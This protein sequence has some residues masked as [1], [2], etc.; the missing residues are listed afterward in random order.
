M[1]DTVVL[2]IHN[3]TKYDA[4]TKVLTNYSKDS[5]TKIH[6]FAEL[7]SEGKQIIKKVSEV[8]LSIFGDSGRH[9]VL[10]HRGTRGLGS[11]HTDI[12]YMVSREK[13]YLEINFS[14]PKFK[15][16]SNVLQF[17]SYYDQ[18]A[19]RVYNDLM[20]FLKL[21]VKEFAI[22]QPIDL[23]DVE[24]NRI[25]FCYN[26]IFLSLKDTQIY[27]NEVK[28]LVAVRYRGDMDNS[29]PVYSTSSTY[30]TRRFSFKVYHKGSEFQKTDKKRIQKKLDAEPNYRYPYTLEYMQDMAD[31]MLRYE[32][33]YRNSFLNSMFY[34]FANKKQHDEFNIYRHLFGQLKLGI[35]G[36]A[37]NRY[38]KFCL[39]SDFENFREVK[40][41]YGDNWIRYYIKQDRV[42]FSYDLFKILFDHF[43]EN[44]KW[45]SGVKTVSQEGIDRKVNEYKA[46]LELN[47][48]LYGRN[49]RGINTENLRG[50][51]ER[52]STQ[53]LK[54]IKQAGLLSERQYFRVKALLAKFGYGTFNP[55]V[56]MIKPGLDYQ[57]Y[58]HHFGAMHSV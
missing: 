12:A 11:G 13:D 16:G 44:V 50:W 17:I 52:T 26:Q 37:N 38:V 19:K 3:L 21:F 48:R 5:A 30:K 32:A 55:Q 49:R 45:A 18:S 7:D 10:N 4:L 27:L 23:T 35:T 8:H 33:T 42:L 46:D 58:K 28:K 22:L 20:I 15:Y 25:D 14:I 56:A 29:I 9:I 1:I 34:Q 53:D 31:R 51:L 36:N 39:E 47:N 54:E 41:K 2:R 40:K 43:W 24:L 6:T 57:S